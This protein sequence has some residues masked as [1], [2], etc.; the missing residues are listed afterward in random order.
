VPIDSQANRRDGRP[1]TTEE[2]RWFRS[3]VQRIAALLALSPT[4]D[5]LYSGAAEDAFTAQDLRLDRS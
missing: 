3:I 1:L 4:L 2:R 5:E